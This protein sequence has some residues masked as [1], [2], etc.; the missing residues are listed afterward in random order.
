MSEEKKILT[1]QERKCIQEAYELYCNKKYEEAR[2]IFEKYGERN[3]DASF[4]LGVMYDFG[5][6]V[7]K[8]MKQAVY[9]YQRAV[10]L[11]D[12]GAMNNLA[13]CYAAGDGIEKNLEKALELYE[14]AAE[15]GGV[16]GSWNLGRWYEKGKLVKPDLK[17]ALELYD[18]AAANGHPDA[19]ENADRIR[20]KERENSEENEIVAAALEKL[21]YY[22]LNKNSIETLRRAFKIL[23]RREN[24]SCNF[25]IHCEDP[26]R[27]RLFI[28]DFIYALSMLAI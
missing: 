19:K 16:Y 26:V 17:K 15:G 20:E 3:A 4:Y 6:G 28:E 25:L 11:G 2:K 9:W 8:D 18:L 5:Y 22:H 14:K 1:E 24:L 10:E 7:N 12:V 27:F 23:Y 13:V 21:S